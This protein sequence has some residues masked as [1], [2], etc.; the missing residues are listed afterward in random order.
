MANGANKNR[1]SLPFLLG[2][3]AIITKAI[4]DEIITKI[5]D[6]LWVFDLFLRFFIKYNDAQV[7]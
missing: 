4:N 5:A 1:N 7:P 6:G 2:A 3:I